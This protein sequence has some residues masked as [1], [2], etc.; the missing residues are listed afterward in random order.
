VTTA[1]TAVNTTTLA[2]NVSSTPVLTPAANGFYRA[3][4]YVVLTQA[5]S[6]TSTLPVCSMT[7]TDADSGVAENTTFGVTN[8]ANT[9]GAVIQ[10]TPSNNPFLYVKSG[11]AIS[12][13]T[14]GYASSGATP[15]QYA[16]HLRLEGPI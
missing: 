9:L 4:C 12:Y 8:S 13:S 16:I 14:A 2:A 10:S 11:V 6:A 15:M 5:A 3:S 1:V 7:W